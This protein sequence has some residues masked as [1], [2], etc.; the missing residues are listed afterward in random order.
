MGK[1]KKTLV[2]AAK[3][4]LAQEQEQ[5]R[6]RKKHHVEEEGLLNRREGQSAEI[7]CPVSGKYGSDRGND[8]SLFTCRHRTGFTGLSGSPGGIAPGTVPDRAGAFH[9]APITGKGEPQWM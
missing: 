2:S 8:F 3:A 9:D 4:D 7:F 6:L 1:F 5:K